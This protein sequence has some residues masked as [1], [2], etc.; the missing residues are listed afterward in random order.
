[1]SQAIC[2][3]LTRSG[4]CFSSAK[5]LTFM[6]EWTVILAMACFAAEE[7][8]GAVVGFG[9]GLVGGTGVTGGRLESS[10]AW[11]PPAAT[12]QTRWSRLAVRT[13][14]WDISSCMTL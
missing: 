3:G 2:T 4:N 6:P 1:V 11:S 12:A 5:R 7:G 13:S 10:T 8:V 9:A 14:R